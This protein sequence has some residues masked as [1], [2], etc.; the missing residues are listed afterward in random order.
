MKLKKV[1]H[2]FC[3]LNYSIAGSGMTVFSEQKLELYIAFKKPNRTFFSPT[4]S[5]STAQEKALDRVE[6]A[7]GYIAQ[8]Q[9]K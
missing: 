1:V 5:A 4:M 2:I 9:N 7:L 8:F 3:I 6:F